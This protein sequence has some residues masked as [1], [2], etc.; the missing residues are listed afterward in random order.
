MRSCLKS[1]SDD[2]PLQL[3]SKFSFVVATHAVLRLPFDF[4]V[5]SDLSHLWFENFLSCLGLGHSV[6]Q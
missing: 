3:E 2:K 1:D 5:V 6:V 4:E